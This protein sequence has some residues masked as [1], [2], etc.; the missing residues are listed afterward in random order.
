[1]ALAS[2]NP[3]NVTF[4][5]RLGDRPFSVHSP[6]GALDKSAMIRQFPRAA[7]PSYCKKRQTIW[8]PFLLCRPA[9][10]PFWLSASSTFHQVPHMVSSACAS[11]SPNRQEAIYIQHLTSK[12]RLAPEEAAQADVR[13]RPTATYLCGD[14]P[15]AGESIRDCRIREP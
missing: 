1:M 7:L 13:L 3:T 2:R 6:H 15:G 12:W 8:H 14:R 9:I 5:W 4:K 11:R 10:W